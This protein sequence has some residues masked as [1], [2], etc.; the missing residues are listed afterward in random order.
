MQTDQTATTPASSAAPASPTE[1]CDVVI[2]GGGPAGA[3]AALGLARKGWRVALV[4]RPG[5]IKPCGGAIPPRLIRDFDIPESQIVARASTARMVSPRGRLVDMPIEGGTV[6]MVD[7]EQF[8]AWL[9]ARAGAAGA[10]LIDGTFRALTRE[11]EGGQPVIHYTLPGESRANGTRRL[12]ARMVIGA[13]GA[14]SRIGAQEVEAAKDK[15]LVFAYH[16]IIASPAGDDEAGFAGDRCEIHYDGTLSPDFYAWIFPHGDSTSVGVGSAQKGFSLK[17]AV[18]E[19]RGRA[20]LDACDTI[21]TEGAPI[22]LKPLK[23]WDNGR[24]VMLAGDAAGCVAPA[25]G[26]GIYYAMI[27]GEHAADAVDEVLRTGDVKAM[28]R[29][30]KRYMREHGKVFWVLGIMQHFWY[31][32]DKRRERFVNMCDDKDVQRLTWDAYMNK[33]LVRAD[34]AA[35]VRIFMKDMAHLMGLTPVQR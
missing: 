14:N 2:V 7:R 16:E 20:S 27:G 19:L 8:D 12:A 34:P 24:D 11:G 17:G 35:H 3:T 9:R 30:R 6:G 23:R 31:R 26:E 33:R 5:R 22:P 28:A 10:R 18:S 32:N 29:A 4:N 21:R 1:T 13:D 25:S 15:D